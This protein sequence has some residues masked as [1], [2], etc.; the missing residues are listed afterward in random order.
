M[1]RQMETRPPEVIERIVRVLV[2]PVSREHVIGDLSE[3]YVSPRQYLVDALRTVPFVIASRIRQTQHPVAVAFISIFLWFCIFYGN[4]QVHWL[5]ATIPTVAGVLS[6][7]L[8][9]VYRTSLARPRDAALDIAVYA[10][11]VAVSQGLVA[12]LAPELLLSKP[13]LVVGFPF[14]CILLFFLR[15]QSGGAGQ[16]APLPS[17][18]LSLQEL[19]NE[20]RG[21]EALVRRAVRIEIGACVSSSSSSPSWHLPRPTRSSRP[22]TGWSWRVRCSSAG[23]SSTSGGV[24]APCRRVS[25]SCKPRRCYRETLELS[26][27]VPQLCVVVRAAAV[28]GAGR[29]TDGAGRSAGRPDAGAGNAGIHRGVL[30]AD[31]EAACGGRES[32]PEADRATCHHG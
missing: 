26:T 9:G 16:I 31:G 8:L 32:C 13:A 19:T 28:T 20:I 10:A 27:I 22:A 1:D 4:K 17:R 25:I 7:V 15:L 30:R 24:G 2:P 21:S 6:F 5:V 23:F 12:L 29:D 14:S 11:F 18:T 3:R